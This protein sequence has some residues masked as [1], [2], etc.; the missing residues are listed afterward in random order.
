MFKPL[1]ADGVGLPRLVDVDVGE[2]VDWTWDEVVVGEPVC[3][4]VKEDAVS[5][6]EVPFTV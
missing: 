5:V 3:E 4:D 1:V 2:L 6:A